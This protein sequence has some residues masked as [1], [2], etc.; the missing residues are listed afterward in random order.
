MQPVLIAQKGTMSQTFDESSRRVPVT[1]LQLD[2]LLLAGIKTKAADGYD[3]LK[4]ALG[5][6]RRTDKPTQGILKKVGI[7]TAPAHIKEV[8]MRSD[9]S[10][11]IVIEAD[12]IKSGEASVKVGATV[13][14]TAI[15]KQNDL[16][17]VTGVSK[18]K[19]FQGGVKR[20]GFAGGPKTHGQSD[21][22]RAPGSMGATTTPGR[23]FKGQRMAGRMGT[24]TVTVR[25]LKVLAITDTSL[26]IQG[27]VPGI[28][29]GI[30]VVRLAH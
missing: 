13:P 29:G 20:H 15:F 17:D 11:R 23:T 26:T 7:E 12:G 16:V 9:I 1:M 22:W 3:A 18:G 8:R 2:N 4:F 10:D 21:R 30:V 19:G 27:L 5:K 6:R 14:A 25:N 28:A 24:E